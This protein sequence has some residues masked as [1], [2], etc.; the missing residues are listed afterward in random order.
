LLSGGFVL[1]TEPGAP[2]IGSVD[3]LLFPENCV[4]ICAYLGPI[5][6]REALA[7]SDLAGMVNPAARRAMDEIRRRPELRSFLIEARRFGETVGFESPNVSR[8]IESMISS[9]AV[10]A[11]QNMV[12]EAVHGVIPK[13]KAGQALAR[14][15]RTFPSA[16]VFVR[17]LDTR[18]VRLVGSENPKH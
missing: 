2:G 5:L 3:R 6:T 16:T 11:A 14:L 4:V 12:G 8:L 9:G 18:G 7:R 1:V 17:R 13:N 10:G 15:Q